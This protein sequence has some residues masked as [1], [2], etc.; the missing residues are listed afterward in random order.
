MK[1][2]PE[3]TAEEKVQFATEMKEIVGLKASTKNRCSISTKAVGRH[4][5]TT[6]SWLLFERRIALQHPGNL[7]R[8]E[9][10]G[11]SR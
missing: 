6:C 5:P 2:R 8:G 7:I 10:K 9:D 11:D 3:A 4:F 1:R